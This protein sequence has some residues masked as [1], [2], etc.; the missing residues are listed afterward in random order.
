MNAWVKWAILAV[1]LYGGMRLLGFDPFGDGS[2][3]LEALQAKAEEG[4]KDKI[5]ILLTGTDW[6]PYCIDLE[7]SVI[8]TEEWKKFA[9]NEVIFQTY[10]FGAVSRPKT[11]AKGDL[12]KRFEVEGFPTMVVVDTNGKLLGEEVGYSDESV[13]Y[14]T[15]WIRSL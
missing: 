11:G 8:S 14:Y 1:A 15:E 5:V 3:S 6:C 12:L 10:L 7:R 13:S 4:G 2:P 9:E